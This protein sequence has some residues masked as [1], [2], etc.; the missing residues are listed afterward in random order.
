[1]DLNG[2]KVIDE[3]DQGVIGKPNLPTTTAGLN[4]GLGYKGFDIAVLF[5]GSFDYN[6]R[7]IAEGI[8]PFVS[9]L[10][11][12]HLQRWTPET[13]GTAKFH[14]LTT[15]AS[16]INSSRSFAS[17]FWM[18][19]AS[20]VRLKSVD[21][22]YKLPEKWLKPVKMSSVRVYASGYNLLTLNNY[23]KYQQD[24]EVASGSLG[25]A[26]PN[27]RIFNFGIQAGF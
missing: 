22:G 25:G 13:A 5:Q 7:I 6:F 11:P 8:E 3:F 10:Q 14:R 19:E 23:D 17:D 21:L 18:I 26:Y 24:A 15:S 1:K 2:D 4:L 20:F 12:I 16:S 9:N 27:S